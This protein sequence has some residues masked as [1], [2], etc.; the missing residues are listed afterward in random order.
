M[1]VCFFFFGGRD[2]HVFYENDNDKN[3]HE[4][5]KLQVLFSLK[6]M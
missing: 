1:K 3:E 2:V 6:G 4:F 5:S